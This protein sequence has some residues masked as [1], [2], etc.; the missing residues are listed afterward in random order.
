MLKAEDIVVLNPR[1]SNFQDTPNSA[2]EQIEWEFRHLRKASAISFWFP[3]E[4]I[5]PIALYELGAYS[6]TDKQLFVGVHPNYK[7][8]T[9][10]EIQTG[11]ARPEI[12]I[13]YQL[14]SLRYQIT[15]WSRK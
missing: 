9:D 14:E 2:Q 12:K 7:R 8:R 6:M 1:R 4:Y 11:L 5:C 13:A 10:V 3:E 15:N